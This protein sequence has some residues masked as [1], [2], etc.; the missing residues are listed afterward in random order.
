MI[1]LVCHESPARLE[2]MRPLKNIF[3]IVWPLDEFLRALPSSS[4]W[5][6]VMFLLSD[7]SIGAGEKS[8]NLYRIRPNGTDLQMILYTGIGGLAVHPVFSPDGN[9]IVFVSNYAGVSAEPIAFP[10]SYQPSG[11]IFV[12]NVDGTGLTRMTH[13]THEDGTP[14]WGRLPLPK[15]DVSTEG[16]RNGCDF[17]DVWFLD[18]PKVKARSGLCPHMQPS[19]HTTDSV[20]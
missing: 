1:L 11:T 6:F 17:D 19:D 5:P 14:S 8:F 4:S 12:I 18:S 13:N 3:I 15:L 7:A 10:H 9:K 2:G 20:L 16:D